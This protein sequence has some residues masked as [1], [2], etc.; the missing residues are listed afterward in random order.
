MDHASTPASERDAA[1]SARAGTA[2]EIRLPADALRRLSRLCGELGTGS[3]AALRE[4][5]R[6]AGRNLVAALPTSDGAPELEVDRFWTELSGAAEDAGYGRVEYRVLEADVG[7]VELRH[8]PEARA[9]GPGDASPPGGCHF[10]SG[11][12]GGA[13]SAAAGEPVAVLEVQCAAED[14]TADCRFLV[15]EERRLE[16]IRRTLR[17][18]ARTVDQALED[19]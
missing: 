11:W 16:E 13:L 18:G 1:D 4:A 6:T 17:Q 5:G 7:E 10:A 9:A 15:G 2:D 14:D 3:I 12:I 8:S 19:R